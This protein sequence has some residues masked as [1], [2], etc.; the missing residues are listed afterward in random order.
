[1]TP[2]TI[3]ELYDGLNR[4]AKYILKKELEVH[5]ELYKRGRLRYFV[6]SCNL[7]CDEAYKY[8]CWHN[9]GSS[10]NSNTLESLKWLLEVI[11]EGAAPDDFVELSYNTL[12]DVIDGEYGELVK[13]GE[14]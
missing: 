10:A 1:M 4:G 11:F 8:I 3:E 9:G 5:V 6:P 13:R 14:E 12:L 2:Y 7:S